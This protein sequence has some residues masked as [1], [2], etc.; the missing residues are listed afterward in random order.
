VEAN[1]ARATATTRLVLCRG[2]ATRRVV[3]ARQT[4]QSKTFRSDLVDQRV[5][6]GRTAY[7]APA[8]SE[9]QGASVTPPRPR[10]SPQRNEAKSPSRQRSRT[11][12]RVLDAR[13][14]V[15]TPSRTENGFTPIT[16]IT[17]RA[18]PRGSVSTRRSSAAT[19]CD[20][21]RASTAQTHVS[22]TDTIISATMARTR[23]RCS[24]FAVAAMMLSTCI[25]VP[26]A[27]LK[28]HRVR[29]RKPRAPGESLAREAVDEEWRHI[30][31]ERLLHRVL[32][33]VDV[34]G[35]CRA[36]KT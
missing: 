18:M 14:T 22:R 31:R 12:G 1:I 9:S 21:L 7:R 13:R 34:D 26:R 25:S 27:E 3:V 28:V 16:S 30:G 36:V 20:Q 19:L 15:V 2:W 24:G 33:R 23:L 35:A 32:R 10:A 4:S 6:A 11:G 29:R 17:C 5:S 8:P